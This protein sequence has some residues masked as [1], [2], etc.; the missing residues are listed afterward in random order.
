MYLMLEEGMIQ[1]SV[2]S[3]VERSLG[4]LP[5]YVQFEFE[6][7]PLLHLGE[8]GR[9]RR[10][11]DLDDA[12]VVVAHPERPLGVDVG[13]ERPAGFCVGRHRLLEVGEVAA[14]FSR[15]LRR[16]EVG[17]HLAHHPP[18]REVVDVH[19]IEPLI[20]RRGGEEPHLLSGEGRGVARF[21]DA[22]LGLGGGG[23]V[24]EVVTAVAQG[25]PPQPLADGVGAQDVEAPA[26]V[27]GMVTRVGSAVGQDVVFVGLLGVGVG[28]DL[29]G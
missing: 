26:L 1:I 4:R 19:L 2:E 15:R 25:V 16:F 8:A 6:H 9:L 12:I 17:E 18:H 23:G 24:D 11:I 7:R 22:G 13:F 5:L 20:L 27:V 14:E 3:T 21:E 28:T 29:G 10:Q